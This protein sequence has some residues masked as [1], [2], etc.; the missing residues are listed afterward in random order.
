MY[1]TQPPRAKISWEQIIA[2]LEDGVVAIDRDGRIVIF[3]EA[4]EILTEISSSRAMELSL[5]QL[6]KRE[7]WI[8]DLAKKTCPPHQE[9]ARGEGDLVTRWGQKV[10]VSVTASPLQDRRD[11]FLGTILL[12]RD[13]KH[14][15]ELEEDLKR[16]DR[17]AMMG[18]FAAGL[19][20]EIR[21]PL[22]GI[23]GAAQLLRR[24]LDGQSLKE[25]TDIMVREVDRVNQLIEH[26]LDLSRPLELSLAPVN[27]HEVL[28]EVLLLE[29]QAVSDEQVKVKKK[30]DPS[31]PPVRAD[32]AQ[33]MQVFLNLVKNAF[34]AMAQG[35]TLTVVTRVETD[36]H[37]RGRGTKRKRL[38]WVDISDEGAGI[39]E[40]DLPH[41]F[42]PFFSTKNSGTGLGLA[43]CYRII[44]EHGGLIRVESTEGKGTT[45]KV[46]LVV[47]E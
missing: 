17:L 7:P 23:K 30:F 18:T 22:G 35:G 41:I 39:K 8:I 27:I 46:S 11:H 32:R 45:F 42:S 4:A 13:I 25:Y 28:D 2:N 1:R 10:P 40:T 33:L 12:L 9:S 14:R 19:A 16:A 5:E 21:N 43:T 6:F 20:H 38:I 47:A 15:R 44:K 31:L 34:Q 29:S 3:N 24:S 36:F 26:L 37:I